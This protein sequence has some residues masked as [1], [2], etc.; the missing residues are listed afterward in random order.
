MSNPAEPFVAAETAL[1]LVDMQNDFLHPD[2]AYARGGALSAPV[3]ALPARLVPVADA[4]RAAGGWI[5][6]THFT[7]VPGRGGAPFISPHL[8]ALRP[9][10]GAGDFLPG[11]FGHG[12]IAELQP[13]DLSVEKVAY[14]AFYQTRLDWLLAR[15]GIRRLVVGGI[16][17]NGGVASTVRDAHVRD[18]PVTVLSD[19]CATADPAMHDLH[20]RALEAVAEVADCATAIAR[21]AA[22]R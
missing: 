12:L 18:I 10:L 7:L 6:S 4:M 13:A 21:L 8:K 11:S 20:I 15:A 2:G 1:L 16:V 14:S 9:F 19:G 5:V 3:A 17:T 22:A